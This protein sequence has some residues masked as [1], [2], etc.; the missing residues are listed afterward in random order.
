MYRVWCLPVDPETELHSVEAVRA[1]LSEAFGPPGVSDPADLCLAFA[2]VTDTAPSRVA[3]TSTAAAGGVAEEV[4]AATA[5]AY[6]AVGSTAHLG[7]DVQRAVAIMRRLRYDDDQI[8]IAGADSANFQGVSSPH[9]HARLQPGERARCRV[10]T[11]AASC[12]AAGAAWWGRDALRT[13]HDGIH[14]NVRPRVMGLSCDSA[15]HTNDTA[16]VESKCFQR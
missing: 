3:R 14:T 12:G 11:A 9:Q 15:T 16:A 10:A 13:Y 1:A 6:N 4:K 2:E 5:A 8:G 7:G